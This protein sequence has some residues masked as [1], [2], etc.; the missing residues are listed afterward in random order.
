MKK[1]ILAG[2]LAV[3]FAFLGLQGTPVDLV[4]TSYA[5]DSYTVQRQ[6]LQRAIDDVVNV[7]SSEVYSVIVANR[8]RSNYDNAVSR[9]EA[10]LND[11]NASYEELNLATEEIVNAKNNLRD[12]AEVSLALIRLEDAI[13]DNEITAEAA[14]IL[15]NNYPQLVAS[16]KSELTSLIAESEA[17]VNEAWALASELKAELNKF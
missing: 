16:V 6:E 10:I 13:E 12:Y 2:V 1:K 11:A 4:S 9:G 7:R 14:K 3:N 17:Y 15:L 5:E 8:L